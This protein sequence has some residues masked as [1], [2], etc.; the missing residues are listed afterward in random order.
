[1]ST[2]S[3]IARGVRT[4]LAALAG[5]AGVWATLDWA[6][7]P[8][9]AGQLI[10]LNVATAAVAAIAAALLAVGDYT[11]DSPLGKALATF[12]QVLGSG[13]AVLAFNSVAD[14]AA[15][16]RIILTTAIAAAFAALGTFATNAAEQGGVTDT[17]T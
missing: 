5:Y 7:D 4:F 14:V 8:V 13:I 6:S 10:A 9:T 2:T 1:M 12:A 3:P 16:G 11:A 15:N 17:D